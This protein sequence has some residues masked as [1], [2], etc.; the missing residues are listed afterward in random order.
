MADVDETAA[1]GNAAPEAAGVDVALGIALS[2][3]EEGGIEPSTVD[4]IERRAVVDDGLVVHGRTEVQPAHGHAP[5]DARVDSERDQVL[6]AF[7]ARDQGHLVGH[8]AYA[9]VDNAVRRELEQCAPGDD[10]ALVQIHRL[11]HFLR[12]TQLPGESG[13]ELGAVGLH[14]VLGLREHDA[15]DENSGHLH[16]ACIQRS[17]CRDAFHLR[18][19]DAAR[20]ARR[21]RKGQIFEGERLA[22]GGDVSIRIRGGAPD[23]RDLDRE[24]L[25]KKIFF[26]VDLHQSH[27]VLGGLRVHSPAVLAWIDV[28]PETDTG[29]RARFAGADVTVHVRKDTLGQVVR[30]DAVV[31]DEFFDAGRQPEITADHAPYEPFMRKP[32][33]SSVLHVALPRGEHQCQF[34]RRPGFEKALLQCDKELVGRAIAS[35]AGR[36]HDIA[37]VDHRNGI[38]SFHDLLEPHEFSSMTRLTGPQR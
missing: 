14:V 25:V 34:T 17:L 4:K 21:D 12:H 19:H 32:V 37:V 9:D 30:L 26:A 29:Q 11:D 35:V 36:S 24:R 6:D 3:S 28:G 7:L 20:I 5:Y 38:R 23:E 22:L 2:K 15:V 13:I 31:D 18:K 33:E 1:T 10:L 27:D 8:R 16:F